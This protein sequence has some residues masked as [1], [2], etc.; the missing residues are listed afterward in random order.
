ML[1]N[2]RYGAIS[3]LGTV[4]SAIGLLGLAY[5]PA[6]ADT[7]EPNGVEPV[8]WGCNIHCNEDPWCG[9]FPLATK[10]YESHSIYICDWGTYGCNNNKPAKQCHPWWWKNQSDPCDA[11]HV[12]APRHDDLKDTCK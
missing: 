1:K 12:I 10:Y 11:D 5:S 3:L 2:I 7:N 8:P 4:V 9:D 6:H